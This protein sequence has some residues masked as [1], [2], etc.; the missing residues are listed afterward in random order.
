MNVAR[1][2]RPLSPP[3]EDIS[4]TSDLL[5]NPSY[6]I[7]TDDVGRFTTQY[8]TTVEPQENALSPKDGGGSSSDS[9]TSS[10]SST[11]SS[12]EGQ[13]PGEQSSPPP[14]GEVHRT[15]TPN[16][17]YSV[18]QQKTPTGMCSAGPTGL[19]N[20]SDGTSVKH[21]S[22]EEQFKQVCHVQDEAFLVKTFFCVS[23]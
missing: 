7:I 17:E 22:Y 15:P 20:S 9:S 19:T 8:Y 2:A 4:E 3:S 18:S 13:P 1:T 12:D 21:W 10:K 23:V 16:M 6:D 11:S 5:S 14:P